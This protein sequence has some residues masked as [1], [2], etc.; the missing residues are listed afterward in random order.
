MDRNESN[1]R[2]DW[3]SDEMYPFESRFFTSMS[4]HR[5][6]FIDEGEGE[7]IVFVHGNPSWSF[8]FRHL[9]QGLAHRFRCVAPDHVGFGLSSRSDRREDYHPES[10]ASRFAALLDRLDLRDLTLFMED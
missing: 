7:P 3:L 4:G 5:M 2:P 6:H 8:E 10:H 9:I 1:V